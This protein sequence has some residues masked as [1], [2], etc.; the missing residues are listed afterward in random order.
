MA[1][2]QESFSRCC[3]NPDFFDRFYAR[4][5]KSHPSIAPMFARTDW[6]EQKQ[7]LRTG[8]SMMIMLETGSTTARNAL[9]RLG[10]KHAKTGLNIEPAL[11]KHWLDSLIATVKETDPRFSPAIEQQWLTAMRKGIAIMTS[12][13]TTTAA[14]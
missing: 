4:F 9:D 1:E 5:V 10:R 11:Y 13:Y 7:L 3:V 14:A 2:P 8:L 6:A 12:F